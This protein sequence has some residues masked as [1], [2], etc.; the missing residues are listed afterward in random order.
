MVSVLKMYPKS[1]LLTSRV[2]LPRLLTPPRR[3]TRLPHPLHPSFLHPTACP[4][5]VHESHAAWPA[6]LPQPAVPHARLVQAQSRAP[7]SPTRLPAT[8]APRV[9]ARRPGLHVSSSGPCDVSPHSSASNTACRASARSRHGACYQSLRL[10]P[11]GPPRRTRRPGLAAHAPAAPAWCSSPGG[12]FL[13]DRRRR[14]PGARRP[15]SRS[16]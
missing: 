1:Q 4:P 5:G 16:V 9:T 15:A 8:T 7:A 10:P 13:R 11:C 6:G 2:S 14:H 12:H 3:A